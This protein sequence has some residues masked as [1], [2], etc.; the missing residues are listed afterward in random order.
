M[1][2]TPL[3]PTLRYVPQSVRKIYYVAAIATQASPTRVE[4]NLGTDL[5]AEIQGMSGFSLTSGTKDTA[6]LSTRFTS[7]IPGAI[8]ADKCEIVCYASS[9]SA[10][11]R[12]VLPRDTVGFILTLWEG[13]VPTQKMDVW[14][15]KVSAAYIDT[16]IADPAQ[17]HVEF[18]VTKV[19]SLN[20]TIPA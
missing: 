19:P 5:T 14:P 16:A 18:V 12:T 2:P 3:T 9:T 4:I 7:Q 8:T 11:V 15:I 10:D 1:A 13:D 17:V 6:D 20:V